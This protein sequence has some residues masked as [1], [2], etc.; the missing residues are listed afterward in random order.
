MAGN[1]FPNLRENYNWFLRS[2]QT[3][4]YNCIG[5]SLSTDMDKI[6]PDIREQDSWPVTLPRNETFENFAAMYRLCGFVPVSNGN[7]EMNKEK[8][9]IYIKNGLVS[10]A[11]RQLASGAW[12]T[13]MGGGVDAEHATPEVLEGCGYGSVEG[14]FVRPATGLPPILPPLRPPRPLIVLP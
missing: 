11:S 12:T 6:W 2:G 7:Y 14:F 9:V 1:P 5:W 8:V 3:P 10:H 13:K 4:R